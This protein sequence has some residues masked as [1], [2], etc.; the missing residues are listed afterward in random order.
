MVHRSFLKGLMAILAVA[1]LAGCA[2]SQQAPPA[3]YSGFLDDYSI[4]RPGVEG[5]VGLIYQYP[6]SNWAS[7]KQVIVEPVMVILPPGIGEKELPQADRQRLATNFWVLLRQ[8]LGKDYRIVDKP[9]PNTLRVQAAL[10]NIE[11][12]SAVGDIVTSIVPVG[13]AISKSKEFMTGKP[14]FVGEVSLEGKITDAQTGTLLAAAVDRRVGG[15]SIKG[16]TDSWD[17]TNK[18]LE[19]W[20]KRIR[21]RLCQWSGKSSCVSPEE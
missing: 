16:S 3:Q 14:A 17:D 18:S 6:L 4:L 1:L 10:T 2:T 5:E 11:K 12:S 19:L 20:S 13:L 9:G 15:K 8:E 21:F 7:F